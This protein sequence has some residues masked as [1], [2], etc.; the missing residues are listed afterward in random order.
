MS[1][2]ISSHASKERGVSPLHQRLE[3]RLE[4]RCES[5]EIR[6]H[7]KVSYYRTAVLVIQVAAV[8]ALIGWQL[9]SNLSA[10]SE[11]MLPMWA[12]ITIF[13]GASLVVMLATKYF[14]QKAQSHEDAYRADR[15]SLE[16]LRHT[17]TPQEEGQVAKEDDRLSAPRTPDKKSLRS[18]TVAEMKRHCDALGLEGPSLP[19]LMGTHVMDA[20]PMTQSWARV[21]SAGTKLKQHLQSRSSSFLAAQARK[22]ELEKQLQG[23]VDCKD[24]NIIKLRKE[25]RHI[26]QRLH[27]EQE[28]YG[29]FEAKL[30]APLMSLEPQEAE[31][32]RQECQRAQEVLQEVCSKWEKLPDCPLRVEGAMIQPK[33]GY[34]RKEVIIYLLQHAH[35]VA[36]LAWQYLQHCLAVWQHMNRDYGRYASY[37]SEAK[38]VVK[39]PSLNDKKLIQEALEHELAKEELVLPLTLD[40]QLKQERRFWPQLQQQKCALRI[41]MLDGKSGI[42]ESKNP[43]EPKEQLLQEINALSYVLE[44][45]E[46]QHGRHQDQESLVLLEKKLQELFS[47]GNTEFLAVVKGVS[48]KERNARMKRYVHEDLLM[49]LDPYV[50]VV[51]AHKIYQ[52][53][54]EAC[55]AGTIGENTPDTDG[56]QLIPQA[57]RQKIEAVQSKI[58]EVQG[59]QQDFLKEIYGQVLELELAHLKGRGARV[60]DFDAKIQKLQTHFASLTTKKHT[61]VSSNPLSDDEQE[62]LKSLHQQEQAT[63]TLLS[64]ALQRK[65]KVLQEVFL[66]ALEFCHGQTQVMVMVRDRIAHATA[67]LS[68]YEEYLRLYRLHLDL[69][70]EGEPAVLFVYPDKALQASYIFSPDKRREQRVHL[71]YVISDLQRVHGVRGS[72]RKLPTSRDV[73]HLLDLELKYDQEKTGVQLT[74]SLIDP[75]LDAQQKLSYLRGIETTLEYYHA[76][77]VCQQL[78]KWKAL[79]VALSDYLALLNKTDEQAVVQAQKRAWKPKDDRYAAAWKNW[80]ASLATCHV[81]NVEHLK[82]VMCEGQHVLPATQGADAVHVLLQASLDI[83]A[84]QGDRQLDFQKS[85]E[86]LSAFMAAHDVSYLYPDQWPPLL[87]LLQ[88]YQRTCHEIEA[89][90]KDDQIILKK[91]PPDV[92]ERLKATKIKSL[93]ELQAKKAKYGEQLEKQQATLPDLLSSM[94]HLALE[95]LKSIQIEHLRVILEDLPYAQV[96]L[97]YLEQ[98]IK[99]HHAPLVKDVVV[100][101]EVWEQLP[102]DVHRVRV[103]LT[104]IEAFKKKH[105]ELQKTFETICLT[106]GGFPMFT[107]LQAWKKKVMTLQLTDRESH[108]LCSSMVPA[109]QC[110]LLPVLLEAAGKTSLSSVK[111]S[112]VSLPYYEG[113]LQALKQERESLER[114]TQLT[115][116]ASLILNSEQEIAQWKIGAWET[117]ATAKKY[118]RDVFIPVEK[119]QDFLGHLETCLASSQEP[120]VVALQ[121]DLE[122]L[123]IRLHEHGRKRVQI[124][125]EGQISLLRNA[126]TTVQE[127]IARHPNISATIKDQVA[128]LAMRDKTQEIGLQVSRLL[129]VVET[130]PQTIKEQWK[131]ELDTMHQ[132]LSP[133][134]Q[135]E[136]ERIAQEAY[137]VVAEV[138]NSLKE[139]FAVQEEQRKLLAQHVQESSVRNMFQENGMSQEM[140]TTVLKHACQDP[141]LR[142]S[143]QE[144]KQKRIPHPHQVLLGLVRKKV[145]GQGEVL[146]E[147]QQDLEMGVLE[148]IEP[149][150]ILKALQSAVALRK[151]ALEKRVKSYEDCITQEKRSSLHYVWKVLQPLPAEPFQVYPH[152]DFHHQLQNIEK[153]LVHLD[154]AKRRLFYTQTLA[155]G[156]IGVTSAVLLGVFWSNPWVALGTLSASLILPQGMHMEMQRRQGQLDRKISQVHMQ[157]HLHTRGAKGPIA[158]AES[159]QPELAL[160]GLDKTC[161]AQTLDVAQTRKDAQERTRTW[162]QLVVWRK[163]EYRQLQQSMTTYRNASESRKQQYLERFSR[164]LAHYL[165][166]H[167]FQ[168]NG[169]NIGIEKQWLKCVYDEIRVLPMSSNHDQAISPENVIIGLLKPFFSDALPHAP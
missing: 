41:A 134:R 116:V 67:F 39:N 105:P 130:I 102:S 104:L 33:Q 127:S 138:L 2:P 152:Q 52:I 15:L 29:N 108:R 36:G 81:G 144:L 89:L 64:Y 109:L 124:D 96:D 114:W 162:K 91:L 129:C 95:K 37:L 30:S 131:D 139:M 73:L 50:H 140:L 71:E 148:K 145:L 43:E 146:G 56:M 147:K 118:D 155:F 168:G 132:A 154:R 157:V 161:A 106:S 86:N 153:P 136:Q 85:L 51:C 92:Q 141:S 142:S 8:L 18:T 135:Q 137:Q 80:A 166:A 61:L 74:G 10:S 100:S 4:A 19:I 160:E 133:E 42:L 156:A 54:F 115:H 88:K 169:Y 167:S 119:V 58:A 122:K 5:F 101:K 75:A 9:G 21:A 97:A 87:V 55:C 49:H 32:S 107:D 27:L 22:S 72:E 79:P 83:L 20:T 69:I 6:G 151:K 16:L 24:P 112:A 93:A 31:L 57:H 13:L 66:E 82:R 76:L 53:A 111:E 113:D 103:C 90:K 99:R 40:L 158:Y 34:Q 14:A 48:K 17:T 150:V 63:L 159:M 164:Q 25:Y 149:A 68:R 98:V 12:N 38:E 110:Y 126:A 3:K 163:K 35:E 23:Q 1:Q 121:E 165:K 60:I 11:P 143:Y 65:A 117:I 7:K 62:Q 26:C 77:A 28:V 78:S 128:C 84:F 46:L 45:E 94:Q 125:E 70:K 123:Q 59:R 44:K 120:A 47:L